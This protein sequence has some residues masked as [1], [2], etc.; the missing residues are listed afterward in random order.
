MCEIS[1]QMGDGDRCKLVVRPLAL[2]LTPVLVPFVVCREPQA[3]SLSSTRLS[4]CLQ[5]PYLH[6][7]LLLFVL[8]SFFDF[9]FCSFFSAFMLLFYFI[10]LPFP[11]SFPTLLTPYASL[12]SH[13]FS[14]STSPPSSIPLDFRVCIFLTS[15]LL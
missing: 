14:L 13:L 15:L 6:I 7:H 1:K 8:H 12:L 10:S 9:Y 11:F 2:V 5:H 3:L 4:S